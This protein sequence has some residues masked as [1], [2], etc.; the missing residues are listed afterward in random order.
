MQPLTK[1]F[2]MWDAVFARKE[3]ERERER[4]KEREGEHVPSKPGGTEHAPPMSGNL[5]SPILS[6]RY[7]FLFSHRRTIRAHVA[8]LAPNPKL[9][10]ASVSGNW[11]RP[12]VAPADPRESGDRSR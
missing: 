10:R 5:H 3:R 2:E 12:P 8:D 4:E 1:L 7:R 6:L 9:V 11:A